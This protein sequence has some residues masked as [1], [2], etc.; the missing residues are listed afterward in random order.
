LKLSS[1]KKITS[2]SQKLEI[3]LLFQ[4]R[5]FNKKSSNYSHR[6]K[7]LKDYT[8]RKRKKKLLGTISLKEKVMRLDMKKKRMK[9]RVIWKGSK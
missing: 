1:S 4:K 7:R 2:L 9:S 5:I 6:K 8:K 3:Q